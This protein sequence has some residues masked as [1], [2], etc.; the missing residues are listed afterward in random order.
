[1]PT[2]HASLESVKTDAEYCSGIGNVNSA[3][4]WILKTRKR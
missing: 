3:P 4:K 2:V 1:M